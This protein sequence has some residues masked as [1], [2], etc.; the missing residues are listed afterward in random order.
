MLKDFFRSLSLNKKLILMMLFLSFVLTSILMVLYS[1][2]EKAMF[3]EF[4]SQIVELSKA[5][6]VGVEEITSQ[7]STD[8]MR[9]YQYLKSLNAKGVKEISIIN[10]A[11]EI[12]ASTNL[13]K[14]G[15]PVGPKKKELIIKAELGESVSKEEG[16]VYNVIVPVIAG[17]EHHGYIHLR[18]NTDD[19]SKVMRINMIKRIIGSLLV[20]A[21]GIGMAMFLSWRYTRPIHDVVSAAKRVAAGD[22]SQ[23]LTTEQKDEIGELTQSFNFMVQK[24]REQRKLEEKLREAEHLSGIGQLS[25]SMAHEI[26]NPLN[27]ISLS[28]DI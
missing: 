2:S 8:E 25:R 21:L 17:Q 12:I 27:F 10:N 7:G 4:E 6:Q 13:T 3:K 14:V 11:D 1:Q 20:F 28:V 19:F 9:L 15:N 16:K 18:I 26:R 24:L 23:T 5:I 22:L